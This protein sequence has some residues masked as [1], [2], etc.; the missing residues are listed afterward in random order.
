MTATRATAEQLDEI[1]A[2][3]VDLLV[4]V[5]AVIRDQ[6][7]RG[8]VSQWTF[9][10]RRPDFSDHCVHFLQDG[11]MSL[12]VVVVMRGVIEVFHHRSEERR[13]GKECR[14]RWSPY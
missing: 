3:A 13:V 2:L 8:L 12:H 14:S 1:V 7:D 10:N 4:R 6:K 9:L 11:E 5:D